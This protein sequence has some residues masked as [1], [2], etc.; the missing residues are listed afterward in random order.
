M[1]EL[2]EFLRAQLDRVEDMARSGIAAKS[3]LSELGE[4][5][6]R[7]VEAKRRIVDL[8]GA[9]PHE[10]VEWDATMAPDT[11]TVYEL[12]CPTLL[13]LASSYADQPGYDGV[14]SR[15]RA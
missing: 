1:T 13:A 5:L 4:L 15:A 11:C 12:D 3:Y 14:L 10:C 2:A 9:A 7:E 8:H 6:L